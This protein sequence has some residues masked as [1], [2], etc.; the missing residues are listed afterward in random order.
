LSHGSGRSK[1]SSLVGYRVRPSAK[2]AENWFVE[3][4]VS[5]TVGLAVVWR[6]LSQPVL[7][8]YFTSR[9]DYEGTYH[10]DPSVHRPDDYR[11]PA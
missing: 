8:E 5:L 2:V 11:R 7:G 6:D 1:D 9:T 10:P 3:I 4:L